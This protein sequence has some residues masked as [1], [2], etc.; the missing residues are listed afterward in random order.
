MNYKTVF[1]LIVAVLFLTVGFL[2]QNRISRQK[3]EISK[4]SDEIT[5]LQNKNTLCNAYLEKQNLAIRSLKLDINKTSKEPDQVEKIKKVY[6][7]DKSCKG[8]LDAYKKLF[9]SSF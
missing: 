8:E 1:S 6:I 5:V 3:N 9:D 2:Q 4:L 7:E